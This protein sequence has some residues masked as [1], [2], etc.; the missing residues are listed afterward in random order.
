M[1]KPQAK[2]NA[3]LKFLSLVQALRDTPTFPVIDATEERLLQQLATAWAA[4]KQVTVLEAMQME[5]DTSPATIHRRLKSLRKKGIIELAVD[6]ADNRVK[7]VKPTALAA[8]YFA[9]I[10]QALFAATRGA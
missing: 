9:Q 2:Q 8:D 3:Y 7:Y 1:S 6:E 4:G 10:N 5:T